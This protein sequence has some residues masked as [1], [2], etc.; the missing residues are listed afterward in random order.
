M[1]YNRCCANTQTYPYVNAP[2]ASNCAN[3]IETG[4]FAPCNQNAFV[5]GCNPPYYNGCNMPYLNPCNYG[6]APFGYNCGCCPCGCTIR[7]VVKCKD[8]E[9]EHCPICNGTLK[10][11]LK[12]AE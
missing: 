9:E 11:D 5:N 8:G 3:T 10:V 12:A 6:Y 7:V 2:F 4:C 1:M